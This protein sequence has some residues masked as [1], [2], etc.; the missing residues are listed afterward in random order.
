MTTAKTITP[1]SIEEAFDGNHST[2]DFFETRSCSR[3][4]G[5][6][7]YSWCAMYGDTCF[8]CGGKGKYF[9]KRG[10]RQEA[11]YVASLSIPVSEVKIGMPIR[12]H[13][14]KKFWAVESINEQMSVWHEGVERIEKSM[15]YIMFYCVGNHYLSVEENELVRVMHTNAEKYPLYVKAL[16][17]K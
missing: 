8:K 3:C 4:G 14:S 16:E 7:R 1:M 9:T 6:G 11:A 17:V 5:C 12:C 10:V 15:K 2:L 13:D